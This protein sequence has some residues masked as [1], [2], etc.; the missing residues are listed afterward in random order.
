M[1]LQRVGWLWISCSQDLLALAFG[2]AALALY[3]RGRRWLAL[4]LL[5]AALASKESALAFPLIFVAWEVWLERRP[6]R[7]LDAPVPVVRRAAL[8]RERI[9]VLCESCVLL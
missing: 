5:L 6:Q 2:L 7:D 1:P 9:R 4:P 3:R 8:R